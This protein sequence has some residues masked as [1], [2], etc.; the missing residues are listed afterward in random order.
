[1]HIINLYYNLLLPINIP[2]YFICHFFKLNQTYLNFTFLLII[3]NTTNNIIVVIML[4]S[5]P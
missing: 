5:I 4:D 3:S 1:M 2:C